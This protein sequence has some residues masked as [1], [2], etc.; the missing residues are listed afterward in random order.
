MT[1]AIDAQTRSLGL[2]FSL[3][4]VREGLWWLVTGRIYIKSKVEIGLTWIIHG[5][6]CVKRKYNYHGKI[7]QC[8]SP[9]ARFHSLPRYDRIA[10]VYLTL[11]YN[12]KEFIRGWW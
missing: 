12:E 8:V 1:P 6:G 11:K 10:A 2:L 7:E 3:L 4:T 5:P 9:E